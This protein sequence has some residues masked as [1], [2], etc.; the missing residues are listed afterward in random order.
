MERDLKHLLHPD[1]VMYSMVQT[2]SH[3][4]SSVLPTQVFSNSHQ[5]VSQCQAAVCTMVYC[6]CGNIGTP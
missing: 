5:S 6:M 2:I 4:M 3:L 1:P